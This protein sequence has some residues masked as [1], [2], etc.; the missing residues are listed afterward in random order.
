MTSAAT[1]V[2]EGFYVTTG[3]R[4]TGPFSLRSDPAGVDTGVDMT[5]CFW[6][7]AG[8]TLWQ[9]TNGIAGLQTQAGPGC[10]SADTAILGGS[11]AA[12]RQCML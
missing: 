6:S 9:E 5:Q 11:A 2:G 1:P 12:T 10:A 4:A 8:A 3:G 7:G